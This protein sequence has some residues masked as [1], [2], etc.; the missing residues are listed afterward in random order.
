MGSEMCIRDSVIVDDFHLLTQEQ[1]LL[2]SSAG[3]DAVKNGKLVIFSG[4]RGI[5]ENISNPT[6]IISLRRLSAQNIQV[7]VR[8]ALGK[9]AI[10]G[11]ANKVLRIASAAAGVPLFA[12]ELARHHNESLALPLR[13][14]INARLDSLHLDHNL[15]REVAKNT[16]GANLEEVATTLGEDVET[17]RPQVERAVASG[18]LSYSADR[19]LTFTHPLLRRAIG[20]SVME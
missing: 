4:R 18:V 12:V 13:V 19:W 8:N 3:T 17:L 5:R 10:K 15:L 14:A 20:N 16:A 7:L 1:Q 9:G 6:A 2:L 11:R